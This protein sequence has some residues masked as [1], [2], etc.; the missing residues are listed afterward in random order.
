MQVAASHYNKIATKL[1]LFPFFTNLEATLAAAYLTYHE[2]SICAN[3]I[4]LTKPR[5]SFTK[6]F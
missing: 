3:G 2:K 4:T 5:D 6:T 1:I